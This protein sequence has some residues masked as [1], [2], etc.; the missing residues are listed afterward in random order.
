M[1]IYTTTKWC[2]RKEDSALGGDLQELALCKELTQSLMGER[3][4][5]CHLCD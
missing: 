5:I 1:C 2:G 3:Y 4:G